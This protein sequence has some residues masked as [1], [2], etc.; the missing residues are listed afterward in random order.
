MA[1]DYRSILVTGG[2]GFVGGH[3]ALALKRRHAGARVIALDNLRRRGSELARA[4]LEGGGV[5]FRHGD[6]RASGDI[7]EIG[8]IDL[9]VD[10]AAEPSVHAGRDGGAAYLIDTNLG[11]T[12]RC[13]E[14]ARRHGADV[15]FL[16]TSRVYPIGGLRALPLA[17][18]G[19]R[20]DLPAGAAGP[21]WSREGIATDFPLVGPRS[22]YGATKLASELLVEEY[23]A[24]FGLRTIV[25][26]CGVVAGPWQMGK[27]DQGFVVLWAAAHV[28]G[29]P[30][31]YRGFGGEGLQV[32]DVLDVEDLASLVDRQLDAIDRIAGGTFNVG[33]GRQGSVSLR[34]LSAL[35]ATL[36]GGQMAVGAV[37]ET[38]PADVPWYVT[39]NAAATAATGWRPRRSVAETLETIVRWLRDHRGML[40]LVLAGADRMTI[41]GEGQ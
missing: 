38:A 7:D 6:V 32:R 27:V 14:A 19:D 18:D 28:F 36:A 16:S 2:A 1:R 17:R 34:E 15:L 20:L 3:L 12:A 33:G 5:A 4:R 40:E 37:A 23:A 35:C 41:P 31:A 10:C 25:D 29:A 21:G 9:L 24:T 26:R 22:L 11:G 13:L 30:L 39:D 8:P